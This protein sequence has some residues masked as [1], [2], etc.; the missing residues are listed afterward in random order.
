MSPVPKD[1]TDWR[2]QDL[3]RL[4][5]VVDTLATGAAAGIFP[6]NNLTCIGDSILLG[7]GG[8]SNPA[9]LDFSSF[10]GWACALSNN[11][12][13][14][15]D[16]QAVGGTTTAQMLATQLPAVLN[17]NP[18]PAACL[19]MGGTNDVGASVPVATS[20]ANIIAICTALS[21]ARISPILCT[22][23]PRT[24]SESGS[25]DL[26]RRIVRY[27]AQNGITCV[28]I[29][30]LLVDPTNGRMQT[31]YNGDGVHPSA[32]GAKLCGAFI[33]ASISPLFPYVTPWMSGYNTDPNVGLANPLLLLDT[34]ADGIPDNWVQSLG[35]GAT[36]ALAADPSA[37]TTT[38]NGATTAG[39]DSIVVTA[40]TGMYVGGLI[41]IDTGALSEQRYITAINGT[42]ISL[43]RQLMLAHSSLVAVVQTGQVLGNVWTITRGAADVAYQCTG[44]ACSVGD[45]FSFAMRVSATPAASGTY[46]VRMFGT[47][48]GVSLV[49]PVAS[50]TLPMDWQTIYGTGIVPTGNTSVKL[51]LMVQAGAA[52]VLKVAQ[53]TIVNLTTAGYA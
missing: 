36:T 32:L 5:D 44:V 43:D 24:S 45:R 53:P 15:Y 30:H 1:Q 4:A 26:N 10:Y 38:L 50:W 35:S 37:A 29:Y 27:A 20:I 7:P 23:P 42:T 19:V 3:N 33:A 8:T 17:L 14:L 46:D 12:F 48:S 39:A 21:A 16:A 49:R 13:Q 31:A 22:I 47:Q 18:K 2:S 11:R 9:Q 52:T 40:N 51:Q 34:N 6:G 25:A 41:T 28:D